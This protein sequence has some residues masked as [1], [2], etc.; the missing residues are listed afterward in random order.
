VGQQ[1]ARDSGNR[2]PGLGGRGEK[3]EVFLEMLV[4]SRILENPRHCAFLAGLER[5]VKT[6][7]KTRAVWVGIYTF[8]P[9]SSEKSKSNR[10]TIPFSGSQN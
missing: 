10:A 6:S 4:P 2:G 8:W 3:R 7:D 9:K 1:A 5:I